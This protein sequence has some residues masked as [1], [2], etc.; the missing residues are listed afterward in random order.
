MFVPDPI[1]VVT[2]GAFVS[3]IIGYFI[4]E[5]NPLNFDKFEGHAIMATIIG[6]ACSV[7]FGMLY[8]LAY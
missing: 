5:S 7:L 3:A 2:I 4:A 6:V 8:V 1:D